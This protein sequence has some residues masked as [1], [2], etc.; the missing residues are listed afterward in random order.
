MENTDRSLVDAHLGGDHTAFGELVH[1]YGDGLLGYLTRVCGDRE[2]AED[3][4][5][6]NGA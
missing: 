2:Q 1:R 5:Q 3:L 4:F 6:Y